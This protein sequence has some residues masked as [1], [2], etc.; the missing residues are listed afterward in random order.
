[1][2]DPFKIPV[3]AV[4]CDLGRISA[5][6]SACGPVCNQNPDYRQVIDHVIEHEC[7]AEPITPIVIFEIAAPT[8]VVAG[9]VDG[10]AKLYHLARWMLF[11]VHIATQ[12]A[13]RLEFFYV[14]PSSVWTKG[15][16]EPVRQKMAK[17]LDTYPG[18]KKPI[19]HDMRECQ[20]MLWFR[21]YEP[22]KWV[23]LASFIDA[24]VG[25]TIHGLAQTNLRPNLKPKPRD[26]TRTNG[27][28]IRGP[29]E[30]AD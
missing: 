1:M 14:A 25:S 13:N 20:A 2:T 12:L 27:K 6:C 29:A 18:T 15:F 3:I 8:S 28:E 10:N 11:N 5:W 23:P 17:V 9:R 7:L 24:L 22:Q 4:D 16:S 26:R 30:R 19:G 21:S